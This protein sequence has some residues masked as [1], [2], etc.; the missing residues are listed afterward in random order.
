MQRLRETI[1]LLYKENNNLEVH[2]ISSFVFKLSK[3]YN[4]V[5]DYSLLKK[6]YEKTFNNLVKQA[7][8][9]IKNKRM[10]KGIFIDEYESFNINDIE[11][12]E[13]FLYEKKYIFNIFNISLEATY[14]IVGE[15]SLLDIIFLKLDY[16]QFSNVSMERGKII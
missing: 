6:D 9:V 5:L 7:K 12:I 14:K 16:M 8:N 13:E 15:R 2:T 10:F 4:L 1:D 11:F 3:K